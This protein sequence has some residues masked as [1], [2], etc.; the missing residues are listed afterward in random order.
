MSKIGT[1]H[2]IVL[3]V[4]V[5]I[6]DVVQFFV[7]EGLLA[8][9]LGI[10][11]IVNEVLDPIV[12][13]ILGAYLHIKGVNMLV[14]PKRL[15]WLIGTEATAAITGGAVQAWVI[16]LY[17]IYRDVKREDREIAAAEAKKGGRGKGPSNVNGMRLPD[18]VEPL[19]TN[20][21][22]EAHIAETLN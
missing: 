6:I 15:L 16:A 18:R 3:F 4:I 12:G 19:N 14:H 2:W 21:R 8:L 22:R 17:F 11:P 10:G 13:L 9:L 7:L 20:K 5:G 1:G